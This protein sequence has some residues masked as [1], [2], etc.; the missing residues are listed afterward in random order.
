MLEDAKINILLTQENLKQQIE[1]Q[2]ITK[3]C[4]N[5]EW[6]KINKQNQ[7]NPNIETKTENTAY[8][9]YTSGS[10]GT[11]K[12]V[13]ITHQGLTNLVNWHQKQF[14]ITSTD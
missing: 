6:E 3:I 11:P 13:E 9:I 10:T 12:G 4:L 8:I 14:K 2:Q 7:N 5:T 1:N